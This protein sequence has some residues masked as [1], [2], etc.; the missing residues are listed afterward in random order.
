VL[1][2]LIFDV[3]T[4]EKNHQI[5]VNWMLLTYQGPL[6]AMRRHLQV[7]DVGVI[8]GPPDR[9]CVVPYRMDEM[10]VKKLSLLRLN[11]RGRLVSELRTYLIRIFQ[12]CIVHTSNYPSFPLSMAKFPDTICFNVF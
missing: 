1:K 4:K 12:N 6:V 8:S 2:A 10:L 7:L 3:V 9:A 5:L 11:M